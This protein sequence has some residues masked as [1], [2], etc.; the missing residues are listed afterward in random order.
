M[1]GFSGETQKTIKVL[2]FI[3]F[4]GSYE[5]G[6]LLGEVI[7]SMKELKIR[8]SGFEVG[9]TKIASLFG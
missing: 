3:N 9:E 2:V 7:T 1:V 8:R 4:N 5:V 6:L